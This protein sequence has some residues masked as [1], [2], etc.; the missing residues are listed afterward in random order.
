MQHVADGLRDDALP[1][2]V[3]WAIEVATTRHTDREFVGI[4]IH[5]TDEVGAGFGNVV[6]MRAF[7]RG[8]F[9][10]GEDGLGTVCFIRRGNQDAFY[11]WIVAGGFEHVHRSHD[12]RAQRGERSAIADGSNGLGADMKNRVDFVFSQRAI[13]GIVVFEISMNDVGLLGGFSFKKTTGGDV[14]AFK[15]DQ[16]CAKVAKHF[17]QGRAKESKTARNEDVTVVPELFAFLG[18]DE[19]FHRDCVGLYRFIASTVNVVKL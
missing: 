7:E 8:I 3:A 13:N 6:G 11:G 5:L 16:T 17:C 2:E 18:V 10:I 9:R 14:V 12:V 1:V 19:L 15:H 4:K